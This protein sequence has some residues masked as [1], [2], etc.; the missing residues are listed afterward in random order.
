MLLVSQIRSVS[1]SFSI[2]LKSAEQEDDSNKHKTRYIYYVWLELRG[3]LSPSVFCYYFL[4]LLGAL[5]TSKKACG[6]GLLQFW[7]AVQVLAWVGSAS[8]PQGGKA[9][10]GWQAEF[11]FCVCLFWHGLCWL[12]LV[13][14]HN[15]A[16]RFYKQFKVGEHGGCLWLFFFMWLVVSYWSKR[17]TVSKHLGHLHN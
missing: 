5:G 2:K 4:K 15:K 3:I 10:W 12:F 9:G 11:Y 6:V 8:L 1:L 17:T 14:F 13:V 7:H 16:K